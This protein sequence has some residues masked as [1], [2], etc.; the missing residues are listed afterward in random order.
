MRVM[1]RQL[2]ARKEFLL[3]TLLIGRFDIFEP[4]LD[5]NCSFE[6]SKGKEMS[7][8]PFIFEES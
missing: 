4:F 6:K 1:M 8:F 2:L 7:T 3:N 5:M